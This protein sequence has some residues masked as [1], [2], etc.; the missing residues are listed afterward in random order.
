LRAERRRAKIAAVK[1]GPDPAAGDPE[2]ANGDRVRPARSKVPSA[3]G[4]SDGNAAPTP[5]ITSPGPNAST[6]TRA[7]DSTFPQEGAPV[8]FFAAPF[9]RSWEHWILLGAA[10]A[11][12]AIMLVLGLFVDPDPRGFGTH[13]SLGLPPCKTM[14]WWN[15]PCPGCGV[16]TSVSLA[17]HGRFWASMRNQPFGFLVAL[18]LPAFAV[19][20]T[21]QT[22]R[23]RDLNNAVHR[24]RFGKWVFLVVGVMLAAWLYKIAL[25]RHWIG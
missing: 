25:T 21:W 14:L 5:P 8:P 22:L 19:W 12:V 23:G 7:L 16:T 4:E 1:P 20:C 3:S 18:A 13:E 11:G 2:G 24:V 17:A 10:F 15:V 6:G 9:G